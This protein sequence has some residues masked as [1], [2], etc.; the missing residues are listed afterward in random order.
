[1]TIQ[2]NC[3]AAVGAGTWVDVFAK[4]K[5]Y[6]KTNTINHNSLFMKNNGSEPIP[7]QFQTPYFMDVTNEYCEVADVKVKFLTDS[8]AYNDFGYLMVFNYRDWV[9][10]G[11]GERDK[12]IIMYRD[13]E[14]GV[15]YLPA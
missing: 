10:T 15:M 11:W 13:V 6:R 8:T 3:H 4:G 5:V 2:N 9:V 12:D 14:P 1:N 7:T